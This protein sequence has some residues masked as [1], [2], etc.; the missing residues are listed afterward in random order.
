[1]RLATKPASKNIE[2]SK[3]S[4]FLNLDMRGSK[5]EGNEWGPPAYFAQV[6][7]VPSYVECKN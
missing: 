6:P 2:R 7:G 5:R 3:S 1:M 4:D